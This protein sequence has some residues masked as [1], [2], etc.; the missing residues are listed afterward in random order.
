VSSFIYLTMQEAKQ[1]RAEK[2]EAKG[3]KAPTTSK[4]KRDAT[5]NEI[6]DDESAAGPSGQTEGDGQ[7]NDDASGTRR[8]KRKKP[9]GNVPEEQ[10]QPPAKRPKRAAKGGTKPNE[11][12]APPGKNPKPAVKK[13]SKP[14][15]GQTAGAETDDDSLPPGTK[16]KSSGGDGENPKKKSRKK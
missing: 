3:T 12:A 16:R 13:G 9:A 11:K 8:S 6:Q 10:P 4:R 7:T 2:K 15:G 1:M 5:A 14:A